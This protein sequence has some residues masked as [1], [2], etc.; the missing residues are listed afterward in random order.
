MIKELK[1]IYPVGSDITIMNTYYNYPIYQDG[2]KI[3]DDFIILVYKDNKTG[4]THNITLTKPEYT[5]YIC[6]PGIEPDH[7]MLF[8]EKEKV[9][10]VNVPFTQ[11]E[12]DIAEKTNKMDFYK[13]NIQNRNKS[14]NRKLHA[15]PKV[16]F[17]DTNI[18]DHYRFKFAQMYSN[19]ISKITK[20]FF[21]IEVD[22]INC[23]TDFPTLG[24]YPIN[25]ISFM[26]EYS[27]ETFTYIL[28]NNDNPLI[29]EFECK[30]KTGKINQTYIKNFIKDSVGGENQ[31]KKY[32]LGDMQYNLL[33]YDDEIELLR[34]F[35]QN[36]HRLKPNFIE[37]Y[38]SSA[39]DLEYIISRIEKLGYNPSDIMCDQ[40][41][42]YKVVKN[43]VDQRNYND[44]AERGDYTFISGDTVW[45]DQMIQYCSRRK[46]KMGSYKSFK[47][48]DI[49]ELETGVKKLDYHHI[50]NKI[51]ELP[52]LDFETFVLYNIM[53]VVVQKCIETKTNDLEYIF[54]KCVINNTVY[55]KGH[56]QTVYLINRMA[57]DWYKDGY[58]I[59]NNANRWN[60]KPPKFMG[61]LVGEPRNTNDYSK[62]KIDGRAIWVCD[63][64]DDYDFK[65]LYPSITLE[66]NISANTQ[67]GKII[68]PEKVYE[69]EN[70]YGIDENLY[71]RGGE[72]TENLITGNIIEF[73][74][75]WMAF[76][77]IMEFIQDINEFYNMDY[78]K[79]LNSNP[80]IIFNKSK[81]EDAIEFSYLKYESPISFRY[82][83]PSNIQGVI[84]NAFN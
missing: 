38:N 70:P 84:K 78:I 3:S 30:I 9:D 36:I 52:Y 71:S 4:L 5:Y 75:R 39:F 67:V 6:K 72:F 27:N 82:D 56:R 63:N 13:T 55:R 73:C 83:I 64:L 74:R 12:R 42:K 7:N 20:S 51:A 57:N 44:F 81:A 48:D 2:K 80:A 47:L 66:D 60:E 46:A 53:D 26:N 40:S 28:R 32:N 14:E 29:D 24:D 1:H 23:P 43:Y 61:A 10:E 31:V 21:D 58:I 34:D 54:T 37:G 15:I 76:A 19:N 22:S 11:L 33:F 16:F 79:Y 65:S 49:G 8:I 50:T 59:G 18:E 68:I 35:F 25:C 62:L 77:G 69:F 41:W 45:M 17:S